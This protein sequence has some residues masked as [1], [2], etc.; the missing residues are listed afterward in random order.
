MG[1]WITCAPLSERRFASLIDWWGGLVMTTFF[2]N[3]SLFSNHSSFSLRLTT[4]PT[5]MIPGGFMPAFFASEPISDSLP[6]TTFCVG[7]VPD[8]I[9]HAGVEGSLPSM[10]RR[11]AMTFRFLMPM[12]NTSVSGPLANSCHL[13]D[14]VVLFSSSWPVINAT[15]DA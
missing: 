5:M 2:P 6:E 7:S 15:V 3:R 1:M 4:L 12:R 9:M 10:T 11:S 13:I 8:W 14:D